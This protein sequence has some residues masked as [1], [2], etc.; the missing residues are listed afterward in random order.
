MS[1]NYIIIKSFPLNWCFGDVDTVLS[2][3][4]LACVGGELADIY[5]P[6]RKA[7]RETTTT[8]IKIRTEAL[9]S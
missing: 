2:G 1:Y 6:Y 8:R 7:C 9:D 4:I 5:P 3:P